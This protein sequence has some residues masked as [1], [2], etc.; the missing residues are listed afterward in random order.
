MRGLIWFLLSVTSVASAAPIQIQPSPRF[1]VSSWVSLPAED[2]SF[3]PKALRS[4]FKISQE[5]H[6]QVIDLTLKPKETHQKMT[7]Y[8]AALTEASVVNILKLNPAQQ[9]EIL[10]DLFD[11]K[12]GA[13]LS[14]VR[15]PMGS[16]D[17]ADGAH[18]EYTYN[19][20]PGNADDS[21]LKHFSMARDHKTLRL[22]QQIM[23][24]NPQVKVM[25]NPWTAPP[26]MKDNR[27]FYRGHFESRHMQAL[28]KY[29]VRTIEEY[30]RFGL[31]VHF[32]G[33]QNEPGISI[34]YPSMLM[35]DQ[36]QSEFIQL[37]GQT[38]AQ[39]GFKARILANDDNYIAIGR[40]LGMLQ[41]PRTAPHIGAVAFHCW[42]NDPEQALKITPKTVDIFE[43]EC[44]GN[45]K[46]SDYKGDF[47]WWYRLRV[48]GTA[49]KN[50]SAI[51]AWNMVSDENA[52]PL[53]AGPQGCKTCRGLITVR[54][55]GQGGFN[56][57]HNPEFD[58]LRHASKFVRRGALRVG[59]ASN[60]EGFLHTAFVNPD[61]SYSVLV[62]NEKSIPRVLEIR[63]AGKVIA[64]KLLKGSEA[65]T[66]VLTPR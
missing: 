14:L 37:L 24:I 30:H 22:L 8:G 66:L 27:H 51:F 13:G 42:S 57:V 36:Q 38:F 41:D 9:S 28:A 1:E 62:N 18:G 5:A 20:T 29:F 17:L 21:E 48:I 59:T 46:S 26:W 32:V 35:S 45:I 55:D 47:N 52:G 15:V 64:R 31:E 33:I 23:K 11:P 58:A 12:E 4:N 63:L 6:Q 25:I 39:K 19:D 43:T 34:D 61:G 40:V 10:H 53:G 60:A 65:T 56:L 50:V 16:S 54:P 44:G 3:R 7:G 49:Q 2:S